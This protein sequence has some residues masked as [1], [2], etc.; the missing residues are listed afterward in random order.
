MNANNV[1]L[2]SIKSVDGILNAI[3]SIEMDRVNYHGNWSKGGPDVMLKQGAKKK[4]NA[5]YKRLM[6]EVEL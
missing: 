5:L 2:S 3:H 1:S 4:L 6:G